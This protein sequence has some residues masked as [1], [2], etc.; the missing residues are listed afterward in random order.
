MIRKNKI[1]TLAIDNV[2]AKGFGVGRVDD[3]VLLIDGALPGEQVEARV[4]KVKKRYGYAKLQRVLTPSPHRIVSPCGV[5]A[6]CGGCQF[7]HG[8]YP[9]Q[10]AIK[11]QIVLDAMTRIGGL[12]DPPV[13]DVLGMAGE[14]FR[15]RNKAV[16]PVV[17]TDTTDGFAIGMYAPRSHRV[18]EMADCL[19]QHPNHTAVLATVKAHMRKYKISAYDET[20]H[21]GT[22]RQVMIRTAHA[23]GEVM[24]VLVANAQ[25]LPAELKL[26]IALIE[27]A[28]ATTVLFSPHTARSNAVLGEAFRVLHGAGYIEEAIG[29]VR[30]RISAPSFFQVNSRQV[31]VLYDTALAMMGDAAR[32]L[33]AHAGAGGIAL[34]AAHHRPQTQVVGV[35][36]TAPAIADAKENAALNGIENAQ[37]HTGAAET[38]VPQLLR[39]GFGP[40]VAVLDPPRRGCETTLL[41]TLVT[42]EIPRIVYISC[43]PATL[44]RDIKRLCEGGYALQNITPVD[45]FPMTGHVEAIA[46]LRR[47]DT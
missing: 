24:V 13:G 46:L 37:F 47:A 12:A 25:R 26:A 34:Y 3:F 45:M 35:D 4:L 30:Y 11:K 8:T 22:M 18:V 19:L 42:A 40:D 7:Q 10:L 15:Y 5:S 6:F 17:P 31:R 41:D 14:P 1:V 43:D 36:I 38:L 23:T 33:D 2:N 20:A 44:A 32:V 29:A 9:L 21:T 39:E 28:E 27:N 16:F